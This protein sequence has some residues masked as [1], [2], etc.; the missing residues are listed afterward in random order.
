MGKE[1]RKTA[2]AAPGTVQGRRRVLKGVPVVPADAPKP[3]GTGKLPPRRNTEEEYE[4]FHRDDPRLD[5]GGD[6]RDDASIEPVKKATSV[7][8]DQHS[9]SSESSRESGHDVEVIDAPILPQAEKDPSQKKKRVIELYGSIRGS[10]FTGSMQM[11]PARALEMVGAYKQ[12]VL[13]P[14]MS[15]TRG[16]RANPLGTRGERAQ[17]VY[18]LLYESDL[19]VPE[20]ERTPPAKKKDDSLKP[21]KPFHLKDGGSVVRRVDQLVEHEQ[22]LR[23]LL[24]VTA[25]TGIGE[26]YNQVDPKTGAAVVPEDERPDMDN[27]L[28]ELDQIRSVKALIS[29]KLVKHEQ[30][31]K[32]GDNGPEI[33]G[34][35]AFKKKEIDQ[36]RKESRSLG[37]AA[38]N[39]ALGG[40]G[41]FMSPKK[42]GVRT[43]SAM[44]I[45]Q[46]PIAVTIISPPP[47]PQSTELTRSALFLALAQS[48][49]LGFAPAA[50]SLFNSLATELAANL[51]KEVELPKTNKDNQGGGLE[52]GD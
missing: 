6:D 39:Q 33:A 20:C 35:A 44:D 46:S 37:E 31:V 40:G 28:K 50:A 19:P 1:L 49:N 13:N 26:W 2:T 5:L 27:L 30:V 10:N 9:S 21:K 29:A 38:V 51:L 12:I 43:A 3:P 15:G 42:A 36:A 11:L 47:A 45:L 25:F 22:E 24:E 23:T 18:D 32:P 8:D 14:E 41:D 16:S 48:A 17:G 7:D 52:G 4:D 34:K